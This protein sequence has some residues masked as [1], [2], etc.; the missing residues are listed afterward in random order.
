MWKGLRGARVAIQQ[1]DVIIVV[2]VVNVNNSIATLGRNQGRRRGGRIRLEYLCSE[3]SWESSNQKCSS[4]RNFSCFAFLFLLL[5]VVS[6]LA[7][8]DRNL[9]LLRNKKQERKTS[10]SSPCKRTAP[11]SVNSPD[12][13]PCRRRKSGT[14]PASACPRSPPRTPTSRPRA[15]CSMSH[16]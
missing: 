9:E 16:A 2:D 14:A 3:S 5:H 12:R 6:S 15:S 8:R 10:A 11:N 4:R 1:S 7:H 13:S